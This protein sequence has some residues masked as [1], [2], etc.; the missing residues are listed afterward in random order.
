MEMSS[1]EAAKRKEFFNNSFRGNFSYNAGV[2]SVNS[3]LKSIT[4]TDN[5][6]PLEGEHQKPDQDI[7]LR[8]YRSRK[9]NNS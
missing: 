5:D 4:R 7:D 8:T 9:M 1:N 6:G 2:S 3:F